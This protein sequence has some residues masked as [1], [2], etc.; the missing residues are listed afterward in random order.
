MSASKKAASQQGLP[1]RL[2]VA[3]SQYVNN[4]AA[5]ASKCN[6]QKRTTFN[7][8]TRRNDENST[9]GTQK[10]AS[11]SLMQKT[12]TNNADATKK[13]KP[14]ALSPAARAEQQRAEPV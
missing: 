3:V 2:I 13:S 11:G 12:K 4:E 1:T 5:A 6:K 14:L 9:R 8:K 10:A 7:K